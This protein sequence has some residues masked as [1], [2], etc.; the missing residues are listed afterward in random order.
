MQPFFTIYT[1]ILISLAFFATSH[2][3]IAGQVIACDSGALCTPRYNRLPYRNVPKLIFPLDPAQIRVARSREVTL[4]KNWLNA[5]KMI[6][7]SFVRPG[8]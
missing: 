4:F 8:R 3:P 5:D 6:M 7:L 1:F 2:K